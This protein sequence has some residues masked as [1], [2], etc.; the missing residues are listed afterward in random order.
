MSSHINGT[1]YFCARITLLTLILSGLLLFPE[2]AAV[3]QQNTIQIENARPGTTAWRL[4]NPADNGEGSQIEGYASATS[5]NRGSPI[6]LFVRTTSSSFTIAIYRLGWYRGLGG[7]QEMA[8]RSFTAVGQPLPTPDP[9]FHMVQCNWTSSFTLTT[10]NPS[11]PTD[12]VSGIYVAKL[13]ASSGRDRYIIF[14]VRDDRSS[15]SLVYQQSVNTYEAYNT[16]GGMSLYTAN[17][18]AVKVSFNRPYSQGWGTGHFLSYEFHMVGFLEK[19]GYDVTYTTNVDTH[20]RSGVSD[21]AQGISFRRS[22]R[23]LVI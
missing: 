18:R 20:E 23:I 16:W 1:R 21:Q 19:E 3:A 4:S 14:V 22:R 10:S 5:V 15:S 2:D 6:R 9:S 12:W 17:P 8:P 7:R 13:K 11:D